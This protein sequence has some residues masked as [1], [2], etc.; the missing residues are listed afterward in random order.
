MRRWRAASAGDTPATR[1]SPSAG[2]NSPASTLSRVLFPQPDGPISDTNPPLGMDMSMLCSTR[3]VCPAWLKSTDTPFAQMWAWLLDVA[4]GEGG[5]IVVSGS[6][7]MVLVGK[8]CQPETQAAVEATNAGRS[9][10]F[11]SQALM[12]GMAGMSNGKATQRLTMGPS[13]MSARL[14]SAP[15][16]HGVLPSCFSRMASSVT[17]FFTVSGAR[18]ASVFLASR[19]PP[20]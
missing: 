3:L 9:A 8:S 5:G 14:K 18:S 17:R 2:C 6:M 1:T 19:K 10:S 7:R 13:A 4:V 11:A 20:R 15:A 12:F 16:T